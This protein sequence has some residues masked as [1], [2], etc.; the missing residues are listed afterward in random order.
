MDGQRLKKRTSLIGG[1]VYYTGYPK[2]DAVILHDT[3]RVE[4]DKAEQ[5]S[6]EKILFSPA[7]SIEFAGSSL[8]LRIQGI[9]MHKVEIA[10]LSSKDTE[11]P[12][13]ELRLTWY[14]SWAKW[15]FFDI[16]SGSIT[17]IITIFSALI[18]LWVAKD[19]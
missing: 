1:Q 7:D 2:K 8:D 14:D 16:I 18:G 13:A 11:F 19:D 4:F 9:L 10:T 3:D 17:L 6:L 12:R 15:D 5:L